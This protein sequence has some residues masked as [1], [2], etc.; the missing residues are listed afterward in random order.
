MKNVPGAA[1]QEAGDQ[2]IFSVTSGIAFS[3]SCASGHATGK[4]TRDRKH[5]HLDPPPIKSQAKGPSL[6]SDNIIRAVGIG[7]KQLR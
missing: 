5:S 4:L 3:Q 1:S 2:D 6:D 7:V